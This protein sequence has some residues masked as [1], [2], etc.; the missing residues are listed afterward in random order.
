[1]DFV[2][3]TNPEVI[4]VGNIQPGARIRLYDSNVPSNGYYIS[5]SNSAFSVTKGTGTT[6]FGV[7]TSNPA[8]TL[9]VAGNINSSSTISGSTL[10]GTLSTAAQPNITS[11]GTLSNLT[12]ANT[13]TTSNLTVLGT[14][15]VLNSYTT[16]SSNFV[17]SNVGT[18]PALKVTQTG[19]QPVAQFVAGSTNALYI[20]SSANVGIGT[21]IPAYPL[22]VVG[23]I[24]CSANI[25]ACNITVGTTT[26][27]TALTVQ[28]DI[29]TS[30][31]VSSGT[32]LM[33]RN[34]VIN[35]DMRMDQRASGVTPVVVGNT[36][37]PYYGSNASIVPTGYSVDRFQTALGPNSGI[38]TATQIPLTAADKASV[39]TQLT[40]ALCISSLP[41]YGLTNYY[42]FESNLN[43]SIGS[44]NLTSAGTSGLTYV[45]G[46]VG[47]SAVYLS[48]EAVLVA[49]PGT[50]TL[51][52]LNGTSMTFGNSYT[53]ALWVQPTKIQSSITSYIFTTLVGSTNTANVSCA[54]GFDNTKFYATINNVNS[55]SSTVGPTPSTGTWYHVAMTATSTKGSG[56]IALYVNGVLQGTLSGAITT[57]SANAILFG[58]FSTSGSN[59][60]AGYLDDV[61]IFNRVLTYS[62][63]SALGGYNYGL[64]I[65]P[66]YSY[67][68]SLVSYFP[69]EGAITSS[70]G[71]TSL[72]VQAGAFLNVPGIMGTQAVYLA[73][74]GNVLASS[75]RAANYLQMSS[76]INMTTTGQMSVSG[77]VCFTKTPLSSQGC[78][79]WE[80]GTTTYDHFLVSALYVSTTQAN[81]YAYAGVNSA[82]T[83]ININTW[84]HVVA[85][86]NLTNGATNGSLAFYVNG[87]LVQNQVQISSSVTS[88][89]AP[90]VSSTTFRMGDN[91]IT[92]V[93]RPFAG[94]LDDFRIHNIVLTQSDVTGLFFSSQR[95]AYAL[96][97]Q[98]MEGYNVADLAWGT[99]NAQSATVSCWL[100]NASAVAQNYTLSLNNN[101]GLMVYLPLQSAITTDATGQFPVTTTG[102][103][104]Y[105]GITGAVGTNAAYFTNTSSAYA[106]QYIDLPPNIAVNYPLTIS[107]WAYLSVN[108][109]NT[110]QPT[111][112]TYGELSSSGSG[113]SLNVN[114]GNYLVLSITT[115]NNTTTYASYNNLSITTWY[116]FVV[117]YDGSVAYLYVNGVLISNINV[118]GSIYPSVP[119]FRIGDAGS[120][121]VNPGGTNNKTGWPGYINDFRLYNKVLTQ[122]QISTLYTN[123]ANST[124]VSSFLLPRSYLYTTPSIPAGTWQNVSFTVPGEKTGWW[125]NDNTPGI[126]LALCL[127]AT[128]NMS[129]SNLTTWNANTV[130]YTGTGT[131][132]ICAS[133]TNL[134]SSPSAAVYLTGLQLEKGIITTPFEV[135]PPAVESALSAITLP[136]VKPD[137]SSYNNLVVAGNISAGNLGM[138]RNRIINGNMQINQRGGASGAAGTTGTTCTN[139]YVGVDRW[140]TSFAIT[141]GVIQQLQVALTSSDTPFT[142]GFKNSTRFTASTACSSYSFF[143]PNQLI[144]GYNISDWNWNGSGQGSSVTLSF[145]FRAAATGSYNYVIRNFNAST[146]SWVGTF[147]A[148]AATWA[149]YTF[150]I[151]PPTGTGAAW[152]ANN[153]ASGLQLEIGGVVKTNTTATTNAWSTPGSAPECPASGYVDWPTTLNNYVEFTGVQLEKGTIATPFEFRPYQMEL[154][155]CHRY[156]E[157]SSYGAVTLSSAVP[158]VRVPYIVPKRTTIAPGTTGSTG[159]TFTTQDAT[160]N[161]FTAVYSSGSAYAYIVYSTNAEL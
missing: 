111:I 68:N 95:S 27:T 24:N 70:G 49:S 36:T 2:S 37:V 90:G 144:E 128:S 126:N 38:V 137:P 46:R 18:G 93:N 8:Y 149:Y 64:S 7:G 153:N 53:V 86:V 22:D 9:D 12:V 125:A 81:L 17:I 72:S 19:S 92:S 6:L 119:L 151:P 143:L 82:S 35:G 40:N 66:T 161:G 67:A 87:N 80:F 28:G 62:E 156:Y 47:S 25:S 16:E 135:R 96:I 91:T 94:F 141:T 34:R 45:G 155:L 56:T 138:F 157:T 107:V 102:S 136:T 77:W 48:N 50:S 3:I 26:A 43:D 146:Q 33:Y 120:G 75:T 51:N 150:T 100:K 1:M 54:I 99:T 61:R 121:V 105:P 52:L 130:A 98:P 148:T 83:T 106:T 110:Y 11:V 78:V 139:G 14:T 109:I 134:L 116:H 104:T 103:V 13:L 15:T 140:F 108:V 10:T 113:I 127:G 59:Q 97:Q 65:P 39:G 55:V 117:T 21:T 112:F 131:Q 69:F 133:T 158:Y 57:S 44:T 71:G 58:N 142:Y 32:G 41:V 147:S 160:V 124:T 4:T 115:T 84:Y 159:A 123:N 30:G 5:T 145:W 20:N 76:T 154:Q 132:N 73:N 60:F 114:A 63:I 23:N 31:T 29:T 101:T 129:T 42:Q 122:T 89:A 152:N 88:T 74:E 118:S 85:T 79:V